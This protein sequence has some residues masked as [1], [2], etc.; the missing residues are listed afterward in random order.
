VTI[1]Q[2]EESYNLATADVKNLDEAALNTKLAEIEKAHEA[3]IAA[4]EKAAA[5]QL[6]A[7]PPPQDA[8]EED[9]GTGAGFLA[10]FL[11]LMFRPIEILFVIAAVGTAYKV[12]SGQMTD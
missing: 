11:L 12:G 3:A 4:E 10:L 6:A 8:D 9:D 2:W 5:A 1:E 7:N